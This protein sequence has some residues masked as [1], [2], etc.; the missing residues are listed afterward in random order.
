MIRSG[1]DFWHQRFSRNKQQYGNEYCR[2]PPSFVVWRKSSRWLDS[3]SGN[4]CA[5]NHN[6]QHQHRTFHSV[7]SLGL[8]TSG[9]IPAGRIHSAAKSK[10]C[11]N[12]CSNQP[13]TF[14]KALKYEQ[15]HHIYDCERVLL[16]HSSRAPFL[17]QHL[18]R[19]RERSFFPQSATIS[20]KSE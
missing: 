11:P 13:T 12:S 4:N 8:D 5:G 6:R 3:F 20:S 16:Q 9:D 10:A 15:C 7:R 2:S 18:H 19:G 17:R 14:A 1:R